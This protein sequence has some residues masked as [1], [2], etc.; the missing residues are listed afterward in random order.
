MENYE[1]EYFEKLTTAESMIFDRSRKY[2]QAEL[3][4]HFF[5]Y[6]FR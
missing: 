2:V 1:R 4:P 5:S 6:I 3:T